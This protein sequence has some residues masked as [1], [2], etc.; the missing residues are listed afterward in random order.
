MRVPR[1]YIGKMVILLWRDPFTAMISCQPEQ[2]PKG[3]AGLAI[4]KEKGT[5]EDIT[6]GVVLIYHSEGHS[7]LMPD[8]SR[9]THDYQLTWVQEVLVEE[10]QVFDPQAVKTEQEPTQ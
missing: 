6:D 9:S 1:S 5:I 3:M 8:Q 4:R 10:I 7:P 2:V